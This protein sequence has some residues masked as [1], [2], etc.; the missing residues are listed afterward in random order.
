MVNFQSFC[1]IIFF[2]LIPKSLVFNI[3]DVVFA[4]RSGKFPSGKFQ[5]NAESTELAWELIKDDKNWDGVCIVSGP[6]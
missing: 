2:Q 3:S 4:L 1:Y 6:T 5:V